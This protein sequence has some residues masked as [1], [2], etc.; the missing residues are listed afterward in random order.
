MY[1]ACA[2]VA[3]S[4]LVRARI[5][6]AR[7]ALSRL[8]RA[9]IA[10]ANQIR[11]CRVRIPACWC[12]GWLATT[13][14]IEVA[15]F[16]GYNVPPFLLSS[17]WVVD[18]LPRIWHSSAL[19]KSMTTASMHLASSTCLRS[20]C[21]CASQSQILSEIVMHMAHRSTIHRISSAL[22]RTTRTQ[23]AVDGLSITHDQI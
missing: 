23:I 18:F 4:R 6:V 22:C 2:R 20:F 13:R 16:V 11:P 19:L 7:V 21:D 10:L 12:K 15:P 1:V 5:P 14:R 8:V 3:L 17:H 9:R